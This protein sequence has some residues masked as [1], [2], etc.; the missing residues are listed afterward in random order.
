MRGNI[1]A[2]EAMGWK[3]ILRTQHLSQSQAAVLH[4]EL[5]EYELAHSH[6]PDAAIW[7]FR[8]VGKLCKPNN[9]LYGL[10]AYD[11]AM[12]LFYD[13]LY[14]ESA[15]LFHKVLIG[16]IYVPETQRLRCAIW[17]RQAEAYAGYHA[18]NAKLGI[19]EEPIY[20]EKS[21]PL[22][23]YFPPVPHLTHYCAAASL[24][25]CLQSLHL[26]S[27][28]RAVLSALRVTGEGSKLSD[29][30]NAAKKLGL[31][32]RIITA[33]EVG[34][35]KL[36][37]PLIAWVERDHFVAVVKADKGGVTYRCIDCGHWP[38]GM[39]HL[40]W[41][42]WQA[43]EPGVYVAI[44]KIG[45][46]ADHLYSE[47]FSKKPVEVASSGGI[48]GLNLGLVT[49]LL[50]E[51]KSHVLLYLPYA[52]GG[53]IYSPTGQHSWVCPQPMDPQSESSSCSACS[54]S[55]KP[56]AYGPLAGNEVNLATGEDDYEPPMPDLMVYNP[57]GPS[58][59]WGR[60]YESLRPPTPREHS[61]E[62]DDFGAGWSQFYNI[63]VYDP[64][65][66][67]NPQVFQGG[68]NT[69]PTTGSDQPASG[70]TWDIVQNGNTIAT[71]SN[72]N[73]WSV[74]LDVSTMQLTVGA[75]SSAGATMNYEARYL[76]EPGYGV[77]AYFDVLQSGDVPQ[78]AIITLSSNGSN[79]P[80]SGDNWAVLQ[81][82][83]LIATNQSPA[84]WNV[85]YNTQS[86]TNLTVTAPVTATIG[87][88]YEARTTS[89]YPPYAVSADFS[90]AGSRYQPQTGTRYLVLPNGAQVSF[91]A[92]SVPTA[93]NTTV[94]CSVEA[95]APMVA[96]W[97]YSS[98]SPTGYYTITFIGRRQ[99]IT[100]PASKAIALTDSNGNTIGHALC[101]LPAQLADPTGYPILFNYGA[102]GPGGFPL[103]STI[104]DDYNGTVLLK[105]TRAANGNV[106][107]V[108]DAYSDS[109]YYQESGYSGTYMNYQELTQV[110][111]VVATGTN[112]PPS[113]YAYDYADYY[114]PSGEGQYAFLHTITVPSP[115]GSGTA[116]GTINYAQDTDYVTSVVDS[117]NN[118][119]EYTA[120]DSNDTQVQVLMVGNGTTVSTY[121]IGFNG[122][123]NP[124]K[125]VNGAGQTTFTAIYS[126][127]NDPYK[128]SSATDGNNNTTDY[129][130]DQFGNITSETLPNGTKT[131]YTY[132]YANFPLGELVSAQEGSQT[133]TS[134]TYY[135]PSGLVA[136]ISTPTPGTS[137]T[138]S[139]VTTSYT[140]SSLGD[141]LTITGPGNNAVN[142]I[143][144]TYNYTQD[145]SYQQPEALGEPL[146][147]TDNLGTVTH[148]RYDNQ[149]NQ[150][151][152]VDA[153]GNETDTTYNI[154]NE[155]ISI[156]YPATGQSGSGHSET[157]YTY[158]YP[159]GPPTTISS[160]NES[161][162]LVEQ[163]SYTY[164]PEGELLSR[165]GGGEAVSYSYDAD[166]RPVSV[167]DGNSN[168][169]TFSYC[170][171]GQLNGITYPKG[172]NVAFTFD[173][174]GNLTKRMDGNNVE[175][176]YTYNA[177]NQLTG[178]SYPA[179]PSLNVT[180]TY[181]AYGRRTQMN[182][183]T[184]VVTYAYDDDDNLTSTTTTYTNLP[185]QT[186][187][188]T[189]Y[190]DGSRQTMMTAKGKFVYDYDGDGRLVSLYDPYSGSYN[191]WIYLANG[192]LA[193]QQLGNGAVSTY[194]YNSRGFL[195][196]LTTK[197][198]G[199]TLLSEFGSMVYDALGNRTSMA[200]NIPA[201]SGTIGQNSY[202]YDSKNELTNQQSTEGS[203]YNDNFGYDGAENPTTFYG[204]SNSYN[205][206]NQNT[207]FTFDGNGNPTVYK[208]TTLVYDPEN[209]L[210]AYNSVFQAAYNGDGL[211]AWKQGS[212]GVTY[213][214]YDGDV[215]VLEL[216][217][218]GAVTAENTWG[219]NGLICRNTGSA[220]YY[221]FDPQGSVVQQLDASQN[222]LS[223]SLYDAWGGRVM[224]SNPGPYGYDGQWGYTTDSETGLLLLTH[225]YYDPSQG[226]F[227]TRD[228]IGY[229]GGVNLYGYVG[230]DA[231]MG[232]DASGYGSNCFKCKGV[233][234][235]ARNPEGEDEMKGFPHWDGPGGCWID[236][237]GY[238]HCPGRSPERIPSSCERNFE[239]AK[240]NWLRHG[241]PV[242]EPK[243]RIS[244]PK[245]NP[246]P[247]P[248]RI[249]GGGLIIGIGL[250]AA[251]EITVPVLI[252]AC[253]L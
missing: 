28:R 57:H 71:S 47:L 31:S 106:T 24:S 58:V 166:Y 33:D 54:S 70:L 98:N 207:A 164:G 15:I 187:S 75:P 251:P 242:K 165:T 209:R 88:G 177:E 167:T 127:P 211:R 162:V 20:G 34:L 132:S 238:I 103:L 143:T 55:S 136:S 202:T 243:F 84:G 153:L 65:A 12:A 42:Q 140:Y 123:M 199:G 157:V 40:T 159:G 155:P 2:G 85:S 45:S 69:F 10:A 215:P 232:V 141:L 212:S 237:Y 163:T 149:G 221:T 216:N 32:G 176:D 80:P 200:V 152:M 248:I 113:R 92:S 156:V 220:T 35:Q 91:S 115:T 39:V 109:V 96:E 197:T 56:S 37:K 30:I 107:E 120:V 131:V 13:G 142:S 190:P 117:N 235:C 224:G 126:D 233:Q 228:P 206:D 198:S 217:S 145:G 195:T 249:I 87:S 122:S 111:Q 134:Y 22:Q 82:G 79:A 144:T 219:V 41:R 223:T 116:T 150:T 49:T 36:P 29:L 227:L 114:D 11:S 119:R 104:T 60:V 151:V 14:R 43:M 193:T 236:K 172:D 161:G 189:Y 59:T 4:L 68:S 154:A 170:A 38:G 6:H 129:T 19:P 230:N 210:T 247:I 147:V 5:G 196:D 168:A 186:L 23:G 146:T 64:T 239:N 99:L 51:L 205:T 253:A 180:F 9:P 77:S 105:I 110:S 222:I 7:H 246:L 139:T 231:V 158:L 173:A 46:S 135:E 61:Y 1:P 128:P 44:T 124:T 81:N 86:P 201:L 125:N 171:C 90:V 63:N 192:W 241:W 74:S 67:L 203:G 17:Y 148:Y 83:S 3:L 185:A 76:Y 27:S 108:D 218:S 245:I 137:G 252:G 208:G 94:S 48:K 244:Y 102:P 204:V 182:D 95:G 175:T 97:D 229:A 138:G 25:V 250:I 191:D 121:T 226:R 53:C 184:G 179:T 100:T 181:D 225:R 72:T 194:T 101:D 183:G 133:P 213:Y 62:S 118:E 174:A 214:I 112:N 78:G 169:T 16:K 93:S 130:W 8:M 89:A 18:I 26:P 50:A 160:Y 240:R 178:I 73:G 52:F 234:W 66:L 188:Y 21:L